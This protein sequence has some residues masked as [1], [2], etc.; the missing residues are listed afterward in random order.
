M[1]ISVAVADGKTIELVKHFEPEGNQRNV[2]GDG[3]AAE[4]I[5][6]VLTRK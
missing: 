1:I 4:R 2:F 6:K 5:V 3:K